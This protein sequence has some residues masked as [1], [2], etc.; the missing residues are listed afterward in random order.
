M[1]ATRGTL[2]LCPSVQPADLIIRQREVLLSNDGESYGRPSVAADDHGLS[3]LGKPNQRTELRFGLRE[4]TK[5][6]TRNST[7]KELLGLVE[8]WSRRA[9]E[10]PGRVEKTTSKG[11]KRGL[12]EERHQS[13]LRLAPRA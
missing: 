6:H 13:D 2:A 8:L 7:T 12:K 1:G 4:R 5:F 3:L 9:E 11:T 10:C